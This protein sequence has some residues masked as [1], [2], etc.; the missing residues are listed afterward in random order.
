MYDNKCDIG[1]AG[2]GVVGRNFA[3]NMADRGFRGGVFNRT[4]EKSRRFIEE[5][6]RIDADGTFHTEWES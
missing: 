5:N 1:L 6:E 3:L 4:D 2:L